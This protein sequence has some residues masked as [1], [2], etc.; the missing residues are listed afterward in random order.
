MCFSRV[1][2][3]LL[4]TGT[5]VESSTARHGQPAE[6]SGN[7][8]HISF[9]SESPRTEGAEGEQGESHLEKARRK[10]RKNTHNA[11]AGVLRV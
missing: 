8:S 3:H 9:E 1:F 4:L 2:V 10:K 5:T 11:E 7:I 6:A